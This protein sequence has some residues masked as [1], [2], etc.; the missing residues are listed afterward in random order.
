[1]EKRINFLENKNAV[2]ALESSTNSKELL[3]RLSA[4]ANSSFIPGETLVFFDEVQVCPEIVTAIKFPV[5]EGSYRYILS[6]SLLGADLK[7]ICSVPAGYMD[8]VEMCP[9]DFEEFCTANGVSENILYALKDCFLKQIPVDPLVHDK[10]AELFKLYIIVGGM[11]AAVKK[12]IETNNL[13]EVKR[14]QREIIAV[15]KKDKGKYDLRNKLYLEDIFDLIPGELNAKNKHFIMKSVDGNFKFSRF[16][17]SF[18][19]LKDAGVALPVF[20]TSEPAVPLMLTK[21]KNLFKLFLSDVGLLASMYPDD[22]QI[23]YVG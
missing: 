13:R 6:G 15:H 4:L 18:I 8:S 23:N 3:S 19:W 9:L 21:C 7:D 11:P 22:V 16:E 5:E 2:R 10:M 1:M 17:N 12:Y 20:C 14:E